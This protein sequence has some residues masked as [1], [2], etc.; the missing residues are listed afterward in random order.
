MLVVVSERKIGLLRDALGSD[1]GAVCFADMAAVGANPARIIP[2][3]RDFV[4]DNR[5]RRRFRGIGEP[6]WAGR[7]A[8]ELIECQH[9]EALLN[10][11]FAE[12][13]PWWLL[14]PYDMASLDESVIDEA[15]R[16]H[17]FVMNGDSQASDDYAGLDAFVSPFDAPLPDPPA[18]ATELAFGPADLAKIRL[19]VRQQANAAGLGRRSGDDLVLA[20]NEITTNSL[21]Y[22]GGGGTLRVWQSGDSLICEI[23]DNG[24]IADPMIGRVQPRADRDGGRGLWLVNQLC[25]L[26][27]LRNF[28]SGTVVRVHMRPD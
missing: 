22:G 5:R 28:A 7:T 4:A 1:A 16:S 18:Q 20:V 15:H 8:E 26:V 21:R 3:W 13:Q 25:D 10:V 11:A 23:A 12:S 14:C 2:V 27:Q 6:I 24:R 19:L 17:P 9:H